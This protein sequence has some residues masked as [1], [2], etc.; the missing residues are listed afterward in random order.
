MQVIDAATGTVLNTQT[1]SPFQGG[2]YLS[3]NISGNVVI[4]VTNLNPSTNAVVSGLF[5]GGKPSVTSATFLGTD[6]TTQ[7]N[8]HGV[9]GADGYDI[10]ADTSAGN[11]KIPSLC[12]PEHHRRPDLRVGRQHHRPAG[13]PELREHRPHRLDV[14]LQQHDELQPEPHRRP[15]AQSLAL[16]GRFRQPSRSEQVQV[17]DAA[18]GTVLS[19]Q[20]LSSF[21]WWRIPVLDHLGQRRDQGHESQDRDE[22]RN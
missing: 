11:P 21:Q 5:F 2:D 9:Y 7:G 15:V 14:V 10:A 16:R 4:K 22:R 20:T 6:T 8:W 19:T 17:I 3:W 13:P 18:T 1:L 12:N